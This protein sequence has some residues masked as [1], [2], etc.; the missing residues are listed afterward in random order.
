MPAGGDA[1]HLADRSVAD[2]GALVVLQHLNV[3]PA[4][5]LAVAG[6]CASRLLHQQSQGSHLE[7]QAQLGLGGGGDDVGEH[8]L[9]LDNDLEDVRHHAAG[10]PAKAAGTVALKQ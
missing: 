9:L 3:Q 1:A 4:D 10:V 7:Q 2:L 6:G 8:A 5:Q